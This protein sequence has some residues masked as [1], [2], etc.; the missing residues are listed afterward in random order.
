MGRSNATKAILAFGCLATALTWT[1]PSSTTESTVA[2][3]RSSPSNSARAA[4]H[5][6]IGK[7][8]CT[9][10]H[11]G[12]LQ[13]KT[14]HPP[15]EESC[16]ACHDYS[17]DGDKAEVK[18]VIEGR[19]LCFTC[20]TDKQEDLT[21]KSS[22]HPPAEESC[23]A[24]H[25]PHSSDSERMLKADVPDLC[26]TC[27]TDKQEDFDTKKFIHPPVR[28]IGCTLCHN[29]HATDD[30]P[31]LKDKVNLICLS[32]H[33]LKPEGQSKPNG[34]KAIYSSPKLPPGYPD[35][36]KKVILGTAGVGHPFL[37][38]PVGGVPDPSREG[39]ELSCKSCHNPHAGNYVQMFQNDLRG[40]ALCLKCHSR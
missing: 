9:E 28:E 17:E 11:A 15:A 29:P 10:C 8:Q 22:R 20:H 21:T 40:Q 2:V 16:T 26:L 18:Q 19:E 31:I 36:A 25:D 5:K 34:S 14:K 12:L 23:T 38:H 3:A 6:K 4:A 1:I 30:K 37:G 24:C 32:C 7:A 13:H 39:V 35:K 33:G 27:H